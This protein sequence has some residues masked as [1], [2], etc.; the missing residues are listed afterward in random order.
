MSYARAR[1][2][3]G[4]EGNRKEM[5]GNGNKLKA[6]NSEERVLERSSI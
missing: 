3:E 5:G 6:G 1:S 4:R 2:L